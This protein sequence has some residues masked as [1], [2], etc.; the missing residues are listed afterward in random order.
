MPIALAD[1]MEIQEKKLSDERLDDDLNEPEKQKV[2]FNLN[3]SNELFDDEEAAIKHKLIN[4]RRVS[5][6][7]KGENWEISEDGRKVLILRGV[8]LTNREKRVLRTV[9]GIKLVVEEYKSGNHSVTKMKS[10]LRE[11]WKQHYD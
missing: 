2:S 6:P 5:L 4:V 7:R 3:Q 1:N 11:Y 10:V 9:E 8:R